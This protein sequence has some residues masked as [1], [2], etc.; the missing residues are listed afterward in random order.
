MSEDRDYMKEAADMLR[1]GCRMR[2]V[3]DRDGE[4]TCDCPFLTVTTDGGG[5]HYC[6][7]T[8]ND[9]ELPMHWRI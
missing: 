1:S 4:L 6:S 5:W 9:I 2:A 8:G 7:L 3:I